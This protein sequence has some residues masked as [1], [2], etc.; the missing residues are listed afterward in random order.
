M[1][2]R[3]ESRKQSIYVEDADE[4]L[5]DG[6]EDSIDLTKCNQHFLFLECFFFLTP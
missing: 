3:Q 2:E 5:P 4:K 1:T 6:E